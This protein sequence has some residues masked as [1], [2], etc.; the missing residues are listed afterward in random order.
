MAEDASIAPGTEIQVGAPKDEL[1]PHLEL[2]LRDV[3]QDLHAD[4]AF[5]YVPMVAFPGR[6]ATKVLVVFLRGKTDVD[7]AL[8][9][10]GDA[11]GDLVERLTADHGKSA[12][13]DL[14]LLP[15][16]LAR[17]LDGL[18]QAVL[19]TDTMLHVNDSEAWRRARRPPAWWRRLWPFASG[20]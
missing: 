3:L 2:G 4:I 20:R 19:L 17:P 18:A 13:E 6:S 11:V 14:D 8:A 15:V 16:S 9:R 12:V 5:A 1:S 7:A 10:I